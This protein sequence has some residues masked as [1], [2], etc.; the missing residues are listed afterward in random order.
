[1]PQYLQSFKIEDLKLFGR[2]PFWKY[3]RLRQPPSPYRATLTYAL[4]SE[5]G[6]QRAAAADLA[7]YGT[8][9]RTSAPLLAAVLPLQLGAQL[10]A[11][12]RQPPQL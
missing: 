7:W 12:T 3:C 5:L 8:A 11:P 1:M 2:D 10:A 9:T 6:S 4:P